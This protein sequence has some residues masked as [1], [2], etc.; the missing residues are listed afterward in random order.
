[1]ILVTLFVALGGVLLSFLYRILRE[2]KAFIECMFCQ[3]QRAK[4]LQEMENTVSVIMF[5][6]PIYLYLMFP[7]F[8]DG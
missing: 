1:M 6:Q 7:I 2:R 5:P 8:V 3:T 4:L